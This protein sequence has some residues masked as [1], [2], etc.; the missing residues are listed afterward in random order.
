MTN[1]DKVS[2]TVNKS[3]S[4]FGLFKKTVNNA[5]KHVK[6]RPEV[7]GMDEFLLDEKMYKRNNAQATQK[8]LAQGNPSLFSVPELSSEQIL[9]QDRKDSRARN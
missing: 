8:S 5:F 9:E 2:Y 1:D 4:H 7:F 6:E 3:K